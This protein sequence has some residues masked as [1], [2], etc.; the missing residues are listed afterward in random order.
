M[1]TQNSNK[2]S[3][4]CLWSSDDGDDD[5]DGDNDNDDDDELVDS[6]VLVAASR[7]MTNC[8]FCVWCSRKQCITEV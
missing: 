1:N 3:V 8:H 5:G 6:T 4:R 2:S 7:K